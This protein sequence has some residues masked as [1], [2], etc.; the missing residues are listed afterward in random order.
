MYLIWSALFVLILPSLGGRISGDFYFSPLFFSNIFIM[1]T[2]FIDGKK[3]ISIFKKLSLNR[4]N[5]R[6]V[7]GIGK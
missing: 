3:K 6:W 5:E 4:K 1:S 2:Y 7:K